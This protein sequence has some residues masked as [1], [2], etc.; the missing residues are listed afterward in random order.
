MQPGFGL[1]QQP[2]SSGNFGVRSAMQYQQ[3][4]SQE[5]PQ[6]QQQQQQPND[7]RNF[8]YGQSIPQQYQFQPGNEQSQSNPLVHGGM[9]LQHPMSAPQVQ[10]STHSQLPFNS[11]Q[12][13]QA[14]VSSA[15]SG[16]LY[17]G[18]AMYP[19]PGGPTSNL[20]QTVPSANAPPLVETVQEVTPAAAP[21][22]RPTPVEGSGIDARTKDDPN[23]VAQR[24]AVTMPA[25]PGAAQGRVALL[26][27]ALSCQL[28]EFL[29]DKVL[30]NQELSSVR[31]PASTKVHTIELLKMLTKDPGYGPKFKLILS[32]IPAWAKYKSQDH[33]LLI[34]GHEQKADY[35]LTDGSSGEK[36][37][38]TSG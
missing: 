5:Q 31:D 1:Q 29:V 4:K 36:K 26:Q 28:C 33:S 2:S 10:T 8:G 15:Q 20:S 32:G 37:L 22:Y 24:Q 13:S 34:T 25:A 30:E 9:P 12:S 3:Q 14:Y 38:L 7:P 18:V 27:Q 16:Q 19:P 35:F 11:V 17:T 6:P 21:Q 23:A